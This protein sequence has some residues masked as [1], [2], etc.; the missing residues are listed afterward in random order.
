MANVEKFE[1][2]PTCIYRFKYEFEKNERQNM[3]DLIITESIVEKNN[4]KVQRLGSQLD[5]HLHKKPLF[6]KLSDAILESSHDLMEEHE[7]EYDSLEITNMWG[8]ILKPNSL[9]SSHQPH[10]HS[11]NFLSGTFYIKASS[12]T[13]S[14]I[15]FDPRPQ[16][17]ILKPR[18]KEF[19]RLN[20]DQMSFDSQIGYG[21]IF[22]SWLQHWV[23]QTKEERISIAWNII[24]RGDYG[25]AG[26]LQNAHI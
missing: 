9:K 2:F 25:E 3:I 24:V 14:I 4:K 5:D 20:S 26:D 10:T 18:K 1:A 21:V 11:N 8:N 22:P 15:F 7:Y 12:N 16:S 23:P 17:S 6:K 13:S 19:N